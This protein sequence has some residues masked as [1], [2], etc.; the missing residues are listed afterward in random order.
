MPMSSIV[1]LKSYVVKKTNKQ[2]D[3]T[4]NPKLPQTNT[5]VKHRKKINYYKNVMRKKKTNKI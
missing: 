5:F 2:K 1:L 3:T 4:K